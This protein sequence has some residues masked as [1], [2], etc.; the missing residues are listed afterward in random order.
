MSHSRRKGAKVAPLL[1]HASLDHLKPC[2]NCSF[3]LGAPIMSEGI[4]NEENA[5]CWY[6][7]VRLFHVDVAF[8]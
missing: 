5:G 7:M 6:E 8:S 3:R 1:I 2:P 4:S